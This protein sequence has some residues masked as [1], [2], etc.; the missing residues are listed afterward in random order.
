M[1]EALGPM[2]RAAGLKTQILAY[3]HNWSEHPN[4]IATHPA[5]ETQD[6][7]DY[8]QEVLSSPAARW[9]AGTAYHC[10]Y[11]DPSAMTTL[12]NAV[13]GQGHL[14]HRM[15]GQRSRATRRTRSR[16]TLKWHARNLI[17]RLTAELGEDR[18]QLERRARPVRRPA[19]RR[20]RQLHRNPHDRTRRP[21]HGQRRVLHARPSQPLRPAGR[22]S[23]RQHGV[24]YHRLERAGHGRCLP[25]PGRDD[26]ARS[27]QRERQPAGVRRDGGRPQLHVHAPG[28]F[29]RHVHLAGESGR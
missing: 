20:L 19:R 17:D 28:R 21:G 4:D 9:V 3:D 1:I 8:P 22:G 6:T 26:R 24:R 18:H 7:N 15:L 25:R 23:D 13:P 29:A 11:G 5:D 10:Y 2:L 16:D 27:P 14:L 12:H